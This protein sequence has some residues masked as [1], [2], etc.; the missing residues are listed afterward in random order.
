MLAKSWFFSE[1]TGNADRTEAIIALTSSEQT[2]EFFIVECDS[3]SSL[4]ISLNAEFKLDEHLTLEPFQ[5]IRVLNNRIHPL[6]LADK[7][8]KTA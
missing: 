2:G 7:I 1:Y 4:C 3:E 6:M 5:A 8:N